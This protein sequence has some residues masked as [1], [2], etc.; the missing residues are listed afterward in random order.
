[1]LQKI[2]KRYLY[3]LTFT[4]LIILFAACTSTKTPIYQAKK[5]EIFE[6]EKV[7]CKKLNFKIHPTNKFNV[8]V[9]L[10]F[11]GE[12]RAQ[13]L[14]AAKGVKLA[15]ER[16]H[17]ENIQLIPIDTSEG[18]TGAETAIEHLSRYNI[19]A[20]IG[21]ISPDQTTIIHSIV[22]NL[23]IPIFSLT[24][25]PLLRNNKGLYLMGPAYDK[26]VPVITDFWKKYCE[27]YLNNNKDIHLCPLYALLPNN[28]MGN[29][30]EN[31]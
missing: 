29:A 12:K 25:E 19:D 13:G 27:D 15:I 8:A 6:E 17:E 21:P 26:N 4:F 18:I 14:N 10:P 28:S 16:Q 30:I 31:S 1:M 22:K 9:M 2:K 20:I 7:L 11:S 5:T 3:I 23:N 24:N